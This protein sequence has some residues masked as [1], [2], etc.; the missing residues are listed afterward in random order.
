VTA[1]GGETGATGPQR[2][3]H[4]NLARRAIAPMRDLLSPVLR[5]ATE[6]SVEQGGVGS[7]DPN[8]EQGTCGPSA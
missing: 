3:V 5:S 1:K 8:D 7:R 2:D 6:I 4:A